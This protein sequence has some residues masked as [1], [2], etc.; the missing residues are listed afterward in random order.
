MIRAIIE[1]KIDKNH[2]RVRIPSLNKVDNVAGATPS[3]ELNIATVA[4]PPGIT[5]SYRPG[6]AVFVDY[7]EMDSSRPVIIGRL[8]VNQDEDTIASDGSFS[9][10][11][12]DVNT[13]LP[14][15]T[16][17]GDVKSENIELLEGLEVNVQES[18]DK[19]NS[20]HVEFTNKLNELQDYINDLDSQL[21]AVEE[22]IDS[23]QTQLNSYETRIDSVES[24]NVAQETKISQLRADLTNLTSRV[25]TLEDWKNKPV[26]TTNSY[27]TQ[28]PSKKFTNPDI[29]QIY[30]W[31]Q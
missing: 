2:Y 29:G 24:I 6:D 4:S 3:D 22:Q 20:N 27:G 16:A 14:K 25:K 5:P 7:E 8:V 10:L 18:F 28:D 9:S 13:V 11:S 23:Q 30:L 19:N 12:V 21:S 1:T 17:I 15:E 26:F 31:I